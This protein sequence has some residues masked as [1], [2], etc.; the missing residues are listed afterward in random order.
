MEAMS[1]PTKSFRTP[2]ART[3]GRGAHSGTSTFW[4]QRITSVLAIPLTIAFVIVVLALVGEDYASTVQILGSAPV[5]VVML[6]IVSVCIY[7]M[8]IGMQE[9]LTDYV[10]D[11]LMLLALMGNTL[12]CLVLGIASCFAVLKLAF[13]M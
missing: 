1:G 5:A 8:W 9:I 4:V 12:F 11:E 3:R 10:H 6:L 13:G 2:F 7:H